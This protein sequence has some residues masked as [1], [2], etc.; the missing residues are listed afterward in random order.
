MEYKRGTRIVMDEDK[1][2]REGIYNLEKI[3]KD[4]DNI[5]EYAGLIKKNKYT[6]ICQG[7]ENEK[8]LAA[9]AIFNFHKLVEQEW[10]TKNVKEWT[11]INRVEG[12][13]NLIEHFKRENE[14][15]WV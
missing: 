12:N 3:Y 5:A 4:I 7:N 13:E 6:Y 11:W 14:G 9:L 2:K 1:I 10:F 15:V 8:D